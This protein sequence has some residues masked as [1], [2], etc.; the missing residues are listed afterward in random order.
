M[1]ML[2]FC[3]YHMG[4]YFRYWVELGRRIPHPPR[5]FHVNWF[6]RDA[7]GKFLW[8]GYGENVRVLKW[9]LER[10]DGKG[11]AVETPIGFLPVADALTLDGL[12][13]PHARVGEL[14]RVDPLDW[15]EEHAAVGQFLETFAT[16]M[17]REL[18]DEHA[19]LGERLGRMASAHG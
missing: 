7:E 12:N 14:L 10:V 8:P 2:P 13:I 4:D 16:R 9:I 6:R 3:G 17:P 1:A 5:I 15:A 18:L 11:R 19:H